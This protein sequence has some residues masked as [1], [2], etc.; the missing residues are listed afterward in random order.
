MLTE[1]GRPAGQPENM[2]LPPPVVGGEKS[3]YAPQ[4]RSHKCA[5]NWRLEAST[6]W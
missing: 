5:F 2:M 3:L 1:N 4:P 6:I